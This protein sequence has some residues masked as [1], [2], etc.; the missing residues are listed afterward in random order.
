MTK[1]C[2]IHLTFC[3]VISGNLGERNKKC[4]IERETRTTYLST[5]CGRDKCEASLLYVYIDSVSSK[6]SVKNML[7]PVHTMQSML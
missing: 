4:D 1:I 6:F 7:Y 2:A 3:C 5:Y